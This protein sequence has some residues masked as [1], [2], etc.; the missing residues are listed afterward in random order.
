VEWDQLNQGYLQVYI[1]AGALVAVVFFSWLF[2]RTLR[3]ESTE[4]PRNHLIREL[5]AD[6]RLAQ[7]RVEE[8]TEQ[9]DTK[10]Q[11]FD[12]SIETVCDLSELLKSRD[13]QID[14][15]R[16]DVKGAVAKTRDLRHELT[17]RA[18]ET[19]REHVRAEA[20]QTELAVARAGSE[21]M[22]SE[23]NRVMECA[24]R[25]DECEDDEA[26][27]ISSGAIHSTDKDA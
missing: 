11:D 23:F 13:G 14:S 7:R 1:A 5:E 9:L 6:L 27:M 8:L 10:T 24:G 2:R 20:A 15:L 26:E 22:A 16:V 12:Q 25:D 19:I 18:T 21:A 3:P 17:E 4:D